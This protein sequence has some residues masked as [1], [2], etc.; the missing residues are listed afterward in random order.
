M[1]KYINIYLHRLRRDISSM[2]LVTALTSTGYIMY[3]IHMNI[4]I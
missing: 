2:T 4:H 3:N 1:N